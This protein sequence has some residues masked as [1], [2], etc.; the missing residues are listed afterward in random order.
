MLPYCTCTD[1]YCLRQA[2]GGRAVRG[3]AR[4]AWGEGAVATLFETMA[5][6]GR[7]VCAG[8]C[9]A[10]AEGRLQARGAARA[11]VERERPELQRRVELS[12][13][14][15]AGRE[16]CTV[17]SSARSEL[18]R[19]GGYGHASRRVERWAGTQQCDPPAPRPVAGAAPCS[20]YHSPRPARHTG[21][22]VQPGQQA[23]CLAG[24]ARQCRRQ[25]RRR[26]NWR[27]KVG[28]LP[29]PCLG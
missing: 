15:G 27:L 5:G 7:H 22:R 26:P 10:A 23:A 1:K 21:G 14:G 6:R 13:E 28:V 16:A 12:G 4:A 18:G 8:S 2:G 29:H 11:P 24:R 19:P 17:F 25:S 3:G 9:K 20:R